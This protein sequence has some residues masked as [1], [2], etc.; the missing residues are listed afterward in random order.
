MIAD[1]TIV[2]VGGALIKPMQDRWDDSLNKVPALHGQCA[3]CAALTGVFCGRARA[4][5]ALPQEDRR[6]VTG[7]GCVEC[8]YVAPMVRSHSWS[9][10]RRVSV[11]PAIPSGL[12]WL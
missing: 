4:G 10:L 2:G 8:S 1:V 12:S 5:S 9:V 3:W 11:L 7:R 6:L